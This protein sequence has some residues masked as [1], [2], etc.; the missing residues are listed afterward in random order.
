MRKMQMGALAALA[1]M[2]VA[3]ACAG[4]NV[5]PEQP[6][7]EVGET[8]EHGLEVEQ[9]GDPVVTAHPGETVVA[10]GLRLAANTDLT[11][12]D[13]V[14]AGHPIL[15]ASVT[16]A[17]AAG[18]VLG[19]S[20]NDGD[21]LFRV[22]VYLD[23]VEGERPI[24]WVSVAIPEKG[25]G[26]APTLLKLARGR[27]QR[28]V[29]GVVEPVCVQLDGSI[30]TFVDIKRP[31]PTL[32]PAPASVGYWVELDASSPIRRKIER[33][34]V[35]HAMTFK[36]CAGDPG[37][38]LNYVTFNAPAFDRLWINEP[39]GQLV[40]STIGSKDPSRIS[41][42][43][44]SY[45]IPANSCVALQLTGIVRE[46]AVAGPTTVALAATHASSL[47]DGSFMHPNPNVAQPVSE[48]DV[49][50]GELEPTP[51]PNPSLPAA[52]GA[53][54]HPKA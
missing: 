19:S 36:V 7:V 33:G 49:V 17:D 8:C 34:E 18:N 27:A 3:M 22:P 28:V 16:V 12:T 30:G 21:D 37:V 51:S 23:L 9:I 53:P 11:A 46:G 29:N 32:E 40:G 45:D 42:I 15:F 47:S 6:V 14:F 38:D 5:V 35:V 39:N 43:G 13:L 24:V 41:I 48:F 31:E 20:F 50:E 54:S 10:V 44:L 1:M 4:G 52:C 2:V 26:Y 25:V